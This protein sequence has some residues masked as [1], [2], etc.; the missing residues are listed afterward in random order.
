M[1]RECWA[2]NTPVAITPEHA[3]PQQ[4]A[5]AANH[6][7]GCNSLRNSMIHATNGVECVGCARQGAQATI[8]CFRKIPSCRG[9]VRPNASISRFRDRAE[10]ALA[11]MSFA[12]ISWQG[13]GCIRCVRRPGKM[14]CSSPSQMRTTM[15]LTTITLASAFVL[16]T[17]TFALANTT[18][19]KHG[20]GVRTYQGYRGPY[21]SY[22]GYRSGG[23]NGT[24]DG[25]TGLV[26]GDTM[27][28]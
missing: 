3:T 7:Q 6:L 18:H 21:N 25:P 9:P 26:G 8:S 14:E 24:A 10:N 15:K 5:A 12:T 28:P 20:S 16:S 19:P 1:T 13:V 17:S 11:C 4:T 23:L 22:G 27:G 2:W